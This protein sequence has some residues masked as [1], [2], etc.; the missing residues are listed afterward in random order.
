MHFK[1]E[2]IDLGPFVLMQR[3]NF[4][5]AKCHKGFMKKRNPRKVK[6]TKAFR[7]GAGKE[8]AVDPVFEM[9]KRRE[10][11]VR[12]DREKWQKIGTKKEINCSLL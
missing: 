3:F 6:W 11:P 12:Y 5:R 2:L 10:V 1:I 4:C 8:L 7:K 9:Q